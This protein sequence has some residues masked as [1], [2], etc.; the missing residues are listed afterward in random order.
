[1]TD[2]FLLEQ[3]TKSANEEADRLKRISAV[4]KSKSVTI[5][6]AQQGAKQPLDGAKLTDVNRDIQAN[7]TAIQEL[8]AQVSTLTKHL[9]KLTAKVN[10]ETPIDSRSPQ[11]STLTGRANTRGRFSQCLEQGSVSCPHCFRSGQ[12]G[13][14]AVGCLRRQ[15]S[16][17][18]VQSLERGSQ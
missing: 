13:H 5:S 8:T 11:T 2:D 16:G 18:G 14:R 3:I 1:M 9:T 12:V 15:R 4:S 6:S 7:Q 10:S 17:N